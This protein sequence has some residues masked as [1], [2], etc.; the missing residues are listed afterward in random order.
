MIALATAAPAAATTITGALDYWGGPVIHGSHVVLVEWGAD[1]DTTFTDDTTGDPAFFRYLASQAGTT[2]DTGAVLAQYADNLGPSGTGENSAN[3]TGY[4]G[5]YK[6]APTDGA[7]GSKVTVTDAEIESQLDKSIFTDQTLPAPSPSDGSQTIY[8]IL[9]PQKD[10]ITGPEGSGTSDVQFCA[11]HNTFASTLSSG[12]DLIYAVIPDNGSG[13]ASIFAPGNG[14]GGETTALANETSAMSH[15][16]AESINDPEIG[17]DT[18]SNIAAPIAWY[19][20]NNNEGEI[21]DICDSG[22][23]DDAHYTDGDTTWTA[24]LLWSTLN[25]N[26]EGSESSYSAPTAVIAPP[27]SITSGS[28][29]DFSADGSTDPMS[30]QIVSNHDLTLSAPLGPEI[31]SYDWNW[32]D[33][34]SD[35]TGADPTHTYADASG[36]P[37]TVT[38][39]VTDALGFTATTSTPVTVTNPAAPD[40][41][42]STPA[43]SISDTG[44][45]VAGTINPWGHASTYQFLYGT[46]QTNLDEQAPM[47]PADAGD[48]TSPEPENTALTDLIPGTPYYYELV[49]TYGTGQTVDGSV[50]SFT[51]TGTAPPPPAP[52]PSTVAASAIG[53]RGA[54]LNGTLNPDGLT[55][56]YDFAWGTSP[57]SLTNTTT[58]TSGPSGASALPVT[59]SLSGLHPG[60]TYY[61]R[62]DASYDDR[63]YSGTVLSFTTATPP[64]IVSLTAP[65]TVS[66][67][68][69]TLNGELNPNGFAA[70]YYFQYG[71]SP[72]YGHSTP[73]VSGVSGSAAVAVSGI[74]AGLLPN[75]TYYYRLVAT[76][77]GGTVDT[78]TGTFKTLKPPPSAPSFSFTVL[79]KQTLA[80]ALHSGIKLQFNCSVA[81]RASFSATQSPAGAIDAAGVPVTLAAGHTKL[82]AAGKHSL[83]LALNTPGRKLFNR[84]KKLKLTVTGSASNAAGVSGRPQ[85]KTLT[86]R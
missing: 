40:V 49:T 30:N 15:E 27:D 14:C 72:S 24:Q 46:S 43:T 55:V 16:W 53:T 86:L 1:V 63:T 6:I 57:S 3:D 74:L 65:T 42:T 2:S 38:L 77:A 33:G 31:A 10:T 9:F 41:S 80:T 70:N 28:A 50:E 85:A 7:G 67:H 60:T 34:S 25:N 58:S 11:Y 69:A 44:A 52:V 66:A 59:G 75:T 5:E 76:G 47:S 12:T 84:S 83:T 82:V 32:G 20:Q 37:Y 54:T 56:T 51:T 62:L 35:S 45:T 17:L 79:G 78:V 4:V 29:A 19:D 81:C 21:A 18:G 39:T 68:A 22:S 73:V 71:P 64:A 8:V 48:G 13:S 61:Y 23:N 26:C 36:S